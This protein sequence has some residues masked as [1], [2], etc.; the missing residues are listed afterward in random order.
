M[1]TCCARNAAMSTKK[2][3]DLKGCD[4]HL[5]A[6]G[7]LDNSKKDEAKLLTVTEA[8]DKSDVDESAISESA[9]ICDKSRP[10][11]DSRSLTKSDIEADVSEGKRK[12]LHKVKVK[13]EPID[14]SASSC[15]N[16]VVKQELPDE[17]SMSTSYEE[18]DET[19]VVKTDW[20]TICTQSQ[21]GKDKGKYDYFNF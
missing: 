20:Y 15:D 16:V 11:N 5:E 14:T 17:N 4:D 9:D 3:N 19:F 21:A 18:Y 2:N 10:Q 1:K 7:T 6:D 13:Q 8:C 12:V